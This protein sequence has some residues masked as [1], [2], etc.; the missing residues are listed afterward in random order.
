MKLKLL[1]L[2]SICLLLGLAS[3]QAAVLAGGTATLVSPPPVVGSDN[4]DRDVIYAFNEKQG[5]TLGSELTPDE[6]TPIASGTKVDSHFVFY[7]PDVALRRIA[8]VKFSG[9]IL[10][11][12]TTFAGQVATAAFENPSTTYL[13]S[14]YTGLE[15]G[16]GPATED[17]LT[18]LAPDLLEVN[19]RAITPG[20]YIRVFTESA[21][22]EPST[23]AMLG[24]GL[25]LVI[26]GYRRR[27]TA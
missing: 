18:I 6:G 10:G 24:L 13:Y 25:G 26:F 27:K 9:P 16:T 15:L 5:V 3:S 8:T 1:A 4:I 11:I 2:S 19:F 7:D 23:W 20:D 12:M 21:V 14:T 22:P 17:Y